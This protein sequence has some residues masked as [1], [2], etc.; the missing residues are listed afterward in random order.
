MDRNAD[1]GINLRHSTTLILT[2]RQR[3]PD[4]VR[5]TKRATWSIVPKSLVEVLT[6]GNFT[7]HEPTFVAG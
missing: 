6:S 3:T 7:A 4:D 5:K 2:R 1:R